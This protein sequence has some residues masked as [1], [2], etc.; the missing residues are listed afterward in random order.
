MNRTIAT[1]ATV[2]ALGFGAAAS[3]QTTVVM[4]EQMGQGYDMLQTALMNDLTALGIDT[5]EI[6]N[7]TLAKIAAIKGIVESDG[8]ES[9]KKGEIEAIIAQEN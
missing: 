3:A 7:L 6:E 1:I 8:S 2:A 4:G 9:N 5:A